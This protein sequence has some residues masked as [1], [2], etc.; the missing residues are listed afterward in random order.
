ME[1]F[2][3]AENGPRRELQ[4]IGQTLN[5][6]GRANEA[7]LLVRDLWTPLL[8]SSAG[9]LTILALVVSLFIGQP[10]SP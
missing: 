10:V 2:P 4:S 5:D 9:L 7:P 3:P 6:L 8:W 1:K